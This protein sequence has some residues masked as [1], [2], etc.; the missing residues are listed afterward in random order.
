MTTENQFLEKYL[1]LDGE[2]IHHQGV[3]YKIRAM[4]YV[5]VYPYEKRVVDVTLRDVAMGN[6]PAAFSITSL[7]D[8]ETFFQFQPA[9]DR[10]LAAQR[11]H[12][13]AQP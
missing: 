12:H 2:H 9:L 13:A 11:D 10:L 8:P 1:E 6:H 4:T 7:C 3:I 5:A